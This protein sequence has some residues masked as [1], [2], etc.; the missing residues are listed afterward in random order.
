MDKTDIL[1]YLTNHK[2]EFKSRF[3][4]A[5]MA[6]FGSFARSEANEGSDI[7]L[8]IQYVNEPG[9]VYT[10]KR[11]FRAELQKH[12]HRQVDL[13]NEKCLKSYAKDDILKDAIYVR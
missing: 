2:E 6:L 12:F 8:L 10:K 3:G 9:D 4:I 1:D 11:L 7:D 13:A 5:A